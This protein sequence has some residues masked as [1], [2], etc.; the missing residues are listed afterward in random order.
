MVMVKAFQTKYGLT[1]RQIALLYGCSLATIQKWRSGSVPVPGITQRLFALMDAI[2]DGNG[3]GLGDFAERF[4]GADEIN[5]DPSLIVSDFSDQAVKIIRDREFSRAV[6]AQEQ[7]YQTYFEFLPDMLILLKS[8][9][10][11]SGVNRKFEEQMGCRRDE[12]IGTAFSGLF[13]E[14]FARPVRTALERTLRGTCEVLNLTLQHH[15]GHPV[16]VE[17][18]FSSVRRSDDV[19]VIC[20]LRNVC[21][22]ASGRNTTERKL[23]YDRLL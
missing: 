2:F 21:A 14:N 11:I 19:F 13:D 4:A 23:R 9:G 18:A 6:A 5:S 20:V 7:E 3:D 10:T 16:E 12:V 17:A 22:A 15:A 8:D 1:N